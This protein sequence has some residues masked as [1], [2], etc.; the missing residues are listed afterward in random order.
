MDIILFSFFTFIIVFSRYTSFNEEYMSLTNTLPVRGI[1]A[2]A[3]VLHHLAEN[4]LGGKFFPLLIHLG[5]LIVAVFFFFSGYG[6]TFSY[7]K[8][9][10][11]YLKGFWKKRILYLIVILFVFAFVYSIYYIVIDKFVFSPFLVDNCWYIYIQIV[12]YI[13]FYI[14]FI[15]FGEKNIGLSLFLL[16][17]LQILLTVILILLKFDSIWIISNFGFIAGCFLAYKKDCID[18]VIKNYFFLLLFV[19]IILFG[20]FSLLPTVV[21]AYYISRFGST[22]VF[23]VIVCLV[24]TK[25]RFKGKALNYL[26]SISLEIYLIHGLVM[27]IL[28]HYIYNNILFSVLTI[29]I[30]IAFAY[31]LNFV[32]KSIKK[33]I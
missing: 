1:M 10:K 16:F 8:K 30:S 13:L 9:G 25:I 5:Y 21:N 11:S 20:G 14:S 29:F 19:S 33:L 2:V 22:V 15:L 3:I 27:R 31:A 7:L 28:A 24:M 23:C 17:V 18:K 26:G 6:L 32:D 12:L 4:N